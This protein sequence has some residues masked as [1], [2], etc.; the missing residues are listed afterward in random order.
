MAAALVSLA[1]PA[2][3]LVWPDVPERVERQLKAQ[4]PS[5]RRAAARDLPSLGRE[6]ATP[7]VLRTL[8]DPDLDVRLAAA[9]AAMTLRLAAAAEAM[10]PWLGEREARLRLSAC[11]MI[12]ISPSAKAIPQLG[13][14]LGDADPQVR[15][16]AADALGASAS[17]EAVAPLLGKL[18]DPSPPVRAQVARSLARLGDARAVV[19]LV[20]KIQDSVP[21][22]RQ[23]VARALGGLGDAR[24]VQALV[25][26]LRDANQEVRI[27]ALA[28]LG[29]LK[30]DGA[31][32]A[33]ASL[34]GDRSGPVRQ[35]AFAALGRIGTPAAIAAL[36]AKLGT[37]DDAS[38]S[39][40]RT[41]VRDALVA[42]GP[43][44][45]PSLRPLLDRAPSAGAA[46]SAAVV[47]GLLG[48]KGAEGDIVTALRRGTVP[49]AAALRALSGAGTDRSIAVVLEF[50][51]DESPLARAEALRTASILLD[52]E[53]PD[54][55]AVEPLAAALREARLTPPERIALVELLGRTGAPRAA[56]VLGSLLSSKDAALRIG[57]L[58]AIGAIGQRAASE[59]PTGSTKTVEEI[60]SEALDDKARDVRFHAALTLGNVGGPR[61]RDSLLG[62]LEGARETDRFA[63]FHALAG[64][65]ERAADEASVVRLGALLDLSAGPERDAILEVLSRAPLSQAV[66]RLVS[67]TKPPTPAEDRRTAVAALAKRSASSPLAFDAL[68]RALGDPD[69]AV[70]AQAAWALGASD[71]PAAV[72]A[73]RRAVGSPEP[74]LAQNVVASLGRLAVKA[75]AGRPDRVAA[76]FCPLLDDTRSPMRENALAGLVENAAVCPDLGRVRAILK[77]DASDDARALAAEILAR[78]AAPDDRQLLE[79]C[80]THDP[81]G[82][83][84]TR[85]REAQGGP[86]KPSP[87]RARER[88]VTVYVAV[89]G[90]TAARPE[91]PYALRYDA[92]YVRA[93]VAD[94]RGAIVE[95]AARGKS[96]ELRRPGG[97]R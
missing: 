63:A 53:R 14:A 7:L 85:C 28:A 51:A 82:S 50:V 23:A 46:T 65:M 35:G 60:V 9:Q 72:D 70:R 45:E 73:L 64:I 84:A 22:V 13:R 86:T 81:S 47:L 15:A 88:P 4:D 21:E 49:L 34:L 37:G 10:L 95:P 77:E 56:S 52:P 87:E 36:V 80:A 32:D 1:A 16:A 38:T 48:A 71:N 12:K 25:V 55:R 91:A 97:V 43:R 8:E 31:V 44:V 27:E 67:R 62:R 11:E 59:K 42:V 75:F 92:G 5:T 39:L 78:S 18:D 17:A 3:A 66:E 19:P 26:A 89:D 6:R 33:I 29:G 83:V 96:L 69:A 30:G 61:T 54:G 94:R 58:D 68:V 57:A 41:A 79:R 93:C 40:E 76:L 24:A 20:G 90:S 2:H 74:D